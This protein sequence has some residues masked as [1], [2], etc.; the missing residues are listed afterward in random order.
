MANGRKFL[1]QVYDSYISMEMNP[2]LPS[3]KPQT[4]SMPGKLPSR[5]E[6]QLRKVAKEL[7]LSRDQVLLLSLQSGLDKMAAA[8]P[9]VLQGA[10]SSPVS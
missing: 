4:D 7:G 10:P 2:A 6:A 3:K 5:L 8:S 1:T 9:P